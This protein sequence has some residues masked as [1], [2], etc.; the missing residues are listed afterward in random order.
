MPPRKRSKADIGSSS[1]S[2]A[3]NYE[4]FL[5]FKPLV[6]K[7]RELC[8][9]KIL[10]TRYIKYEE[11]VI[12]NIH[13]ILFVVGLH[14]LLDVEHKVPYYPFLVYLFYANLS[15]TTSAYGI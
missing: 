13:E 8:K 1:S 4:D 9:L 15:V 3:S 10:S 6:K 12:Y 2:I 5:L 14:D 11:L 7:Y